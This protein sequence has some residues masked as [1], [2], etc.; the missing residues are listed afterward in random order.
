MME[1]RVSDPKSGSPTCL[2]R[3]LVAA[4][5]TGLALVPGTARAYSTLTA[6]PVTQDQNV[7]VFEASIPDLQEAMAE[8]R[9]TS[10]QLVDAYLARIRAYDQ[11][12]PALNSMIRLNPD[13]LMQ[14]AALDQERALMGARGPLHGIPIILKDNYDVAGLPTSG[15]SIA[16]AGMIPPDDAFQVGK[17]REAGAVIIGKSNMHELAYGITTIS[18]V[19]G[20][21]RNPYD[22]SRNPGGSSGGT[23]AAIAASF[24]AIGWGSDTCGSIRIPA[25]HHNLFGL[26]P[27]KGLS[28]IDGIIP[29]SHTQDVGGPLARTATDLAIALDATIGADPADPATRI[30][31]DGALPRFFDGLDAEALQGARIGI[32]STLFGEAADDREHARMVRAA[33]DSMSAAG[34]EVIDV[35]IP[36]LDSLLS[37]SSL[38]GLEFKWDLIDYLAAT[39]AAPVASVQEIL[40]GGL[41]HVRLEGILRRTASREERDSAAIARAMDKRAAARDAVVATMDELLLDALVYPTIRRRAA[42]IGDPQGGSNCQLSATTGL[43]ALSIPAGFTGLGLPVGLELLGR[44]LQDA[45]LLALGFAFEQAFQPRRAPVR[46]PPLENGRAPEPLTFEVTAEGGRATARVLFSWDVTTSALSYEVTVSGIS[47]AEILAVAL[48]RAQP[49]REGG[50]LY[51]LSGPGGQVASGAITLNSGERAGLLGGDFYLRLYTTESP[52][53]GP[54]VPL[55]VP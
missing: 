31:A 12:G 52:Y 50:V 55:S 21:T 19:G 25:S 16:L 27:T 8:G 22:P 17:L 20:Q 14:A 2:G 54:R 35:E 18:S 3:A 7:E 4:L 33:L 51:R 5:A 24:A 15:G 34:A 49:E 29:L 42:R 10:V 41:Y 38:I 32:L 48:H 26:R 44:P 9:V 47:A 37:G 6:L 1:S 36:G 45:R 46:T 23:G 30:L 40:D 13:A 39:P 11:G 53:G 43:P 28:S